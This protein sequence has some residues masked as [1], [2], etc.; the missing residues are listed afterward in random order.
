MSQ[1][2]SSHVAFVVVLGTFLL[3][4]FYS[5][6]SEQDQLMLLGTIGTGGSASKA[7]IKNHVTGKLKTYS[8]GDVIALAGDEY[9]TITAVSSCMVILKSNLG[10][11]TLECDNVPSERTFSVPSPLARFSVIDKRLGD[12]IKLRDVINYG[13]FESKFENEILSAS[14]RYGVD[15]Y[16]I[17]AVIKVE[18]NFNPRAVSPKKAMGIMQLIPETAS[19]YGVEDPFDP[20]DNI[21]GGVRH[22]RDLM[23]YFRGDLELVLS[24]YNAGK[25]AVIKYGYD[26]PPYPETEAYVEKVL[27]YYDNINDTRYVSWR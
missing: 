19:I 9:A 21:D 2:R 20:E 6:C 18:S 25:D 13:N 24:A 17:K 7:I 27:A 3:Y 5:Q 26:I 15:P 23:E 22:L 1:M 4:P 12:G 11:E 14:E 16:L 10:Y 8:E